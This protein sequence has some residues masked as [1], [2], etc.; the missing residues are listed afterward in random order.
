MMVPF[1]FFKV[2]KVDVLLFPPRAKKKKGCP[3]APCGF[4]TLVPGDKH[5]DRVSLQGK[6]N[7][8]QYT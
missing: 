1:Y 5:D 8:I 3:A 6:L 4:I 7:F 2:N